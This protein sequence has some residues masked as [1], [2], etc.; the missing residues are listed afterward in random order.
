[1]I[2]YFFILIATLFVMNCSTNNHN[3]KTN[4]PQKEIAEVIPITAANLRGHKA[5]YKEG[6]FVV[7]SSEKAFNYAKE[8]AV[9]SSRAA[10][11]AAASSIAQRNDEFRHALLANFQS[12]INITQQTFKKGE[13]LTQAIAEKSEFVKN[14]QIDYGQESFRRSW[15][16]LVKG[17]LYLGERT[18]KTRK[19]LRNQ[20]GNYFENLS[21]DFSNI[22]DITANMQID[23]SQKI[24]DT[25]EDAFSESVI[26]F[27]EEYEQSGESDNS[28]T[29]L[30]HILKGYAKGIYHGLFKPTAA[31][32]TTT[33]SAGGRASAQTIFLPT[34]TAISVAGRTVQSIGNT[35]YYTGKL[36]I[37]IISPT[38][39]AGFLSGMA[40][41]SLSSTPIAKITGSTIGAVNQIAFLAASPV[42]GGV[43]AAANTAVDTGKHVTF[44]SY[45][46]IKGSSKV[47][48]NQSSSA[49]V[50]GYNALTAIPSHLFMG[51]IDSAVFLAWDGPRLVIATA[52]GELI[53]NNDETR[54]DSLPV[55]S[56]VDLNMLKEH[57]ISVE[58]ISNDPKVINQIME[59][60]PNDLRD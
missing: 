40:I 9:L 42:I 22:Y 13:K 35:I 29:G 14:A 58:V 17:N 3:L 23:F 38:I 11:I 34:S 51:V 19:N 43:S 36:G 5:L 21:S 4:K 18:E 44:V 60:L 56:V 28:L 24:G 49:I 30:A 48:I 33:L 32:A 25:W 2:K 39:E 6:W 55:G 52:K 15:E 45:D 47:L 8:K 10:V 1:M 59:Q 53:S 7:T 20:P 12:S 37:E 31:T 54:V 16:S 57:G 26:L 27:N 50:L 46:A 41:L